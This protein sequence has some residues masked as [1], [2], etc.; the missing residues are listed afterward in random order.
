MDCIDA[1]TWS[2]LYTTPEIANAIRGTDET[3]GRLCMIY[4]YIKH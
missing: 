2:G 3:F 1:K 4:L